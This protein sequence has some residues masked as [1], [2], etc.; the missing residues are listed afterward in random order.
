MAAI[1]KIAQKQ[2][3]HPNFFLMASTFAIGGG[4]RSKINGNPI[5]PMDYLWLWAQ[6]DI[7]QIYMDVKPLQRGDR[8]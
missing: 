1:F 7:Y 2:V 6:V 5:W 4:P 8:L 3:V